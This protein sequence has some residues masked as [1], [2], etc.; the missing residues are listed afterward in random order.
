MLDA[1]ASW[2]GWGGEKALAVEIDS[3]R[4]GEYWT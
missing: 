3:H 4:A 1:A 2:V